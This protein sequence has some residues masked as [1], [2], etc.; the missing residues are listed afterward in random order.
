MLSRFAE[1][2]HQASEALALAET[3][4]GAAAPL[5]AAIRARAG[6]GNGD[7]HA[8]HRS[9]GGRHQPVAR[10]D[11]GPPKPPGC[12][13][14]AR[15]VW[16]TW[17]MFCMTGDLE[18]AFA[19][20]SEALTGLRQIGDSY[21]LGRALHTL[22]LDPRYRAEWAQALDSLDEAATTN[23][24]WAIG[25]AWATRSISGLIS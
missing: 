19:A 7:Y 24:P 1:A 21:A 10:G 16:P 11:R 9:P 22:A 17:P 12:G 15:A 13:E 6:C 3:L 5:A 14:S 4:D 23:A 2:E 20:C 8:D 18:Q 25:R